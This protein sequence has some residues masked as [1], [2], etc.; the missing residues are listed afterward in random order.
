MLLYVLRIRQIIFIG[1]ND[2]R[3]N[4]GQNSTSS[5]WFL[6]HC[7]KVLIDFKTRFGWRNASCSRCCCCCSST[8]V[9]SLIKSWSSKHVVS[10]ISIRSCSSSRPVFSTIRGCSSRRRISSDLTTKSSQAQSYQD[11]RRGAAGRSESRAFSSKLG[12]KV[13]EPDI[14]IEIL[15]SC[16]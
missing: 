6:H 9:F 8:K 13:W 3:Y 16:V 10:L 7:Q 5:L 1:V 12:R 14:S 15:Y 11:W 4:K 2:T